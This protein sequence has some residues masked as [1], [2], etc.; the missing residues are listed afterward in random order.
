[1]RCRPGLR[2]RLTLGALALAMLAIAGAGLAVYGLARTQSLAA[3]ALAAQRRIEAYGTLSSRVNEWMLGW[4]APGGASPDAS[5]VAAAL[6]ELDALV[7]ADIAGARSPVEE[8]ER[9]KLGIMPARIRAEVEALERALAAAPSGTPAGEGAAYSAAQIPAIAAAAV[10]QEIRRRDTAMAA[11]DALRRRLHRLALAVA[12][13]APLIVAGLYFWLLRPL[14]GRL[15]A[16]TA[17]AEGLAAGSPAPGLG[18]HDE[19]G[20]LFSR[21]RLV[22]ARLSRDRAR[23]GE[24]VA[25]R[26]AELSRANTRLSRIDAERRRFFADVGHE[27]RTPL[28]VILGEAELGARHSDAGL[29]ASFA[30]IRGRA[31]RLVRR[32]EDLLRIARSETGQLE[33]ARASV[34]LSA[35]ARA[36]L[37]DARPLLARAGVAAEIDALPPLLVTG[38]GD[39]LRQVFAGFLENAAKY[40]GRGAT[41][42]IRGSAV[43][44]AA[45][46]T[47]TD[48]GPGLAADKHEAVFDRFGRA[49]ADA[50]GFGVGLALAR[51]VVEAHGGSLRA[52]APAEGGLRLVMFL[53]LAEDVRR[54]E[55]AQG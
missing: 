18:G 54:G 1:V 46:V 6:E 32:I 34:D 38:D 27:L 42:R 50:P 14:F 4:L 12:I 8:E 35:A 11:M 30:T 3:E 5:H 53:P 36:A 24:T 49:G 43:Q 2:A 16:A 22:A 33:L 37:D 10:Q 17:G 40:A 41:V 45:A 48:D 44:G 25:E 21:L 15:A 26:T 31:L 13:A 55:T 51:W 39:W 28:T 19:L 9:G 47:V 29:R 20:L 7:K 52:E 23:L